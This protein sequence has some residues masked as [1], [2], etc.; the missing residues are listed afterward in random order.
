[1]SPGDPVRDLPA[2]CLALAEH[3][4]GSYREWM[5]APL[6]EVLLANADLAGEL[7]ERARRAKR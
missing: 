7:E 2:V 3:A 6:E 1:M 4:G 5:D